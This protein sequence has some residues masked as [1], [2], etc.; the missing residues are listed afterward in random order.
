MCIFLSVH[1]IQEVV[2]ELEQGG[3][4]PDTPVAVVEHASLHNE[5]IIKG[6]LKDIAP[7]VRKAGMGRT[8]MIIVGEVINPEKHTTSRLYNKGFTH[9]FRKGEGEGSRSGH[10]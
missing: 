7:K 1:L 10:N 4:S 2:A 8:A 6:R 5:E 9:S 3:Y